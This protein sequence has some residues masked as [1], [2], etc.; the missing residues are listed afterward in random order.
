MCNRAGT[1]RATIEQR[2]HNGR[3][4]GLCRDETTFGFAHA[5]NKRM[6]LARDHVAGGGGGANSAK[7]ARG[8]R[9]A[10]GGRLRPAQED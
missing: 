6:V 10:F 1:L 9:G 3:S 5:E 2:G 4:P 8:R 7:I